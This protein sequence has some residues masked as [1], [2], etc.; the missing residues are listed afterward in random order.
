[1]GGNYQT[2]H[3]GQPR[4]QPL[5][6]GNLSPLQWPTTRQTSPTNKTRWVRTSSSS[7][8]TRAKA[9]SPKPWSSGRPW[10][11][12]TIPPRGPTSSTTRSTGWED[13][14]RWQP[15][16]GTPLPPGPG[17]GGCYP[18]LHRHPQ[19]KTKPPRL[20]HTGKYEHIT[21][22]LTSSSKPQPLYL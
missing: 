15:R 20:S 18:N 3:S 22:K 1:M 13:Q 6:T 7:L 14:V 17:G 19:T 16:L 5:P 2:F 12:W 9:A 8:N 21:C 10:K 11:P 4:C